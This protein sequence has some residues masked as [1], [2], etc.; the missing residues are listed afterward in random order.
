LNN[1]IFA[2]GVSTS[3]WFPDWSLDSSRIRHLLNN[4]RTPLLIV[5]PKCPEPDPNLP[6]ISHPGRSRMYWKQSFLGRALDGD[7]RPTLAIPH[8]SGD[9]RN[10]LK[11]DVL[12][13]LVC[14]VFVE[15][16]IAFVRSLVRHI[17]SPV[18]SSRFCLEPCTKV[19][20]TSRQYASRFTQGKVT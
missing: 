4:V 17:P 12:S 11:Q 2:H 5:T 20:C 14:D 15:T 8:I 1:R 18:G 19:Q 7:Y 10:V 9:G 13:R 3:C 6:F 16:C